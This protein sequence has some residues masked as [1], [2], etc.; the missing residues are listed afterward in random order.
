MPKIDMIFQILEHA[1]ELYS[2]IERV[3]V[4]S[5]DIVE[6]YVNRI[7]L[8]TEWGLK[9]AEHELNIARIKADVLQTCVCESG[10]IAKKLRDLSEDAFQYSKENQEANC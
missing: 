6:L 9:C 1:E 10:K 7:N 8:K 3:S 5:D 2:I 4:L